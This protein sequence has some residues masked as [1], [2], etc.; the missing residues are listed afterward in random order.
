MA[1]ATVPIGHVTDLYGFIFTSARLITTKPGIMKGEQ[2][3]TVIY[4]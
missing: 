1:T 2:T 4:I 3:P